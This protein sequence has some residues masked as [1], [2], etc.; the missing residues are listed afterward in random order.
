MTTPQIALR[1]GA[2]AATATL[3]GS[4]MSGIGAAK[5]GERVTFAR[6]EGLTVSASILGVGTGLIVAMMGA[7]RTGL[8]IGAAGL[9]IAGAAA[10]G[11]SIAQS[12]QG[13]QQIRS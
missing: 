9:M 2:L 1:A 5:S 7:P 6:T 13:A 12:V 8:A 11:T 4:A 10:L 3:A